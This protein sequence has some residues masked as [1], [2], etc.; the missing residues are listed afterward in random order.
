MS[1]YLQVYLCISSG[2][3]LLHHSHPLTTT[4]AASCQHRSA[5]AENEGRSAKPHLTALVLAKGNARQGVGVGVS[6]TEHQ[7]PI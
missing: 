7:D 3:C 4:T 1:G 6:L 5:A 2:C